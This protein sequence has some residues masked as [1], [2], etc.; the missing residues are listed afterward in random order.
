M[1]CFHENKCD[2]W[3]FY[4]SPFVCKGENN[5][6][7][8]TKQNSLRVLAFLLREN[9]WFCKQIGIP[10]SAL[11]TFLL[12]P[13]L[14]S[15]TLPCL[16]SEKN[17]QCPLRPRSPRPDA[18]SSTVSLT[19]ILSCRRRLSL[20]FFQK[21]EHELTSDSEAEE[22]TLAVIKYTNDSLPTTLKRHRKHCPIVSA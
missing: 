19:H 16:L 21:M 10:C 1:N 7:L 3:P 4:C 8:Q 2:S 9:K 5:S 17:I 6:K 12:L 18:R 13:C 20:L 15:C 22:E 11:L 14:L